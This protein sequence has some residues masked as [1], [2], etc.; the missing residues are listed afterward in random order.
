MESLDDEAAVALL[1]PLDREPAAAST[2]NIDLAMREGRRVR[3]RRTATRAVA[4]IA[5]AGLVLVGGVTAVAALRGPAGDPDTTATPDA[6]SAS[7]SASTG[8]SASPSEST[9][10]TRRPADPAAP[11]PVPTRCTLSQLPVPDGVK[12]ALVTG[13]D[14]TGRF[15][16][17]R[18][19]LGDGDKQT[20]MWRDGK[21]QKV[22]LVGSE[23]VLNDVTTSGTA[24]GLN[25]FDDG[26]TPVVY[27]D[28]AVTRLALDGAK[29]GEARGIN[30]N[31]VIAGTL[32]RTVPVRWAGPG[33]SPEKLP[34]PAASRT[35]QASDIDEDGTIVGWVG[36]RAAAYVW[37]PDGTHRELPAP[38]ADGKRPT[39]ID[40]S[41]IR[42]GWVTGT[43]QYAVGVWRVVR[44]NLNTGEAAVFPELHIRAYGINKHGWLV[45]SAVGPTGL[46]RTDTGTVTLTGLSSKSTSAGSVDPTT[47]SDDG[48]I[49]AGQADDSSETI[50]AVIW[51]CT[52]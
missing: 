20:L 19:Y 37:F 4:A 30:E 21:V 10:P 1:R 11:P 49:V 22:P 38:T 24:V 36:D 25:Y 5:A 33:S 2:I 52:T 42:N 6:A 43:A 29:D 17:G 7:A 23:P 18:S 26:P 9:W 35:G 45:A 34:L 12:M 39:E 14:P 41:S 27:R 31:G 3:R 28:G 51:H 8:P 47:I 46:I 32:D 13:A 48:R 50:R 16:V 44:W 40:A 15:I